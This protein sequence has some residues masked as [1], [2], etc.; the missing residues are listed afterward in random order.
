MNDASL[1][2]ELLIGRLTAWFAARLGTRVSIESLAPI[3]GGEVNDVRVVRLRLG[4]EWRSYLLRW[5]PIVGPYAP[6]DMAGQFDRFVALRRTSI[7]VPAPLWLETDRSILGRDFWVSEF[8]TAET[9]GRLLDPDHPHSQA[10]GR[11]FLDMLALI[12]QAD[13]SG[14][15][16]QAHCPPLPPAD[17]RAA[18]EASRGVA[19]VPP[20]DVALWESVRQRLIAT[21]PDDYPMALVHGDCSLSNY[22]FQGEEIVAV[23]DWD[24]ARITDPLFDLGYYCAINDRFQTDKPE[25]ER[26]RG[27]DA[28]VSGY[29]ERTGAPLDR[30]AFWELYANF[31]NALSWLRPG[32]GTHG[33]G[34]AA[35]RQRLVELMAGPHA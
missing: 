5:D 13:W 14:A 16:L 30:L 35:Y 7:P 23:V 4:N 17:L 34:Y 8:V 26:R 10:R 9:S 22:L 20:A 2:P 21:A 15:G 11:A 6:Y 25:A 19:G 12:H 3:S 1:T 18:I 24:L 32:W 28:V 27:R 31:F 29:R 33:G